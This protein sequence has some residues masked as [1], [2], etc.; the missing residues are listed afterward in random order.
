VNDFALIGTHNKEI[1]SVALYRKVINAILEETDC[2]IIVKTH[3]YEKKKTARGEDITYQRLLSLRS[4]F[5]MDA[6]DR[7]RVY[8]EVSVEAL[9]SIVD[10]IV[11]INSQAAL[12]GLYRGLPVCV[13]SDAFYARHGFTHD[14][15]N[16]DEMIMIIKDGTLFEFTEENREEFNRFMTWSL[17]HCYGPDANLVR[18]SG[19]CNERPSLS[20][21]NLGDGT[22]KN[23]RT[24]K[25]SDKKRI[26]SYTRFS[27][28]VWNNLKNVSKKLKGRIT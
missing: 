5:E 24:K 17:Q 14:C 20:K 19:I 10:A 16:I 28:N 15:K 27:K 21:I 22:K 3:P 7:I 2:N 8:A 4:K 25:T 26:F 18:F 1:G 6:Q 9:F 12:E 13:L 11:T 23:D